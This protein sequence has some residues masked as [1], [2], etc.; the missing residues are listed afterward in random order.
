MA[1]FT[2][3]NPIIK[4]PQVHLQEIISKN[5]I[6]DKIATFAQMLDEQ[7]N[8]QEFTVL[9]I[10]KGALCLTADL[11]RALK[12]DPHLKFIRCCSYG[13]NGIERG[14]LRITGMDEVDVSGKHVLIVDDICDS[15][16]T[17]SEVTT[18]VE[19]KHPASVKSLVLLHRQMDMEA[20]Y[21]PDFSLFEIDRDD[22][23]VGYGLDYK[24]AYRGLEAIYSMTFLQS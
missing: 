6:A 18:Q 17:L 10:M 24:E 7:Y 22:F 16:A 15:G 8:G 1:I 2:L 9:A 11:I 19:D 12:S 20:D 14:E 21:Y 5:E 23:V 13:M 3:E 4:Q